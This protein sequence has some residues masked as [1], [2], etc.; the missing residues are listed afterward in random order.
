MLAANHNR[1]PRWRFDDSQQSE[2]RRPR[3]QLSGARLPHKRCDDKA[4]EQNVP[5]RKMPPQMP[6]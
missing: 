1:V 3:N 6:S 2:I 5:R 4:P